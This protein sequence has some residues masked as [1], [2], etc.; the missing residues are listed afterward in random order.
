[1]VCSCVAG[2]C[3]AGGVGRGRDC[4]EEH[5]RVKGQLLQFWDCIVWHQQLLMSKGKDT[6]L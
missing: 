6:S 5:L 4:D 1:M 3:G 2:M